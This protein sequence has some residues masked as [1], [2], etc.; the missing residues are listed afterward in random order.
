MFGRG[1]RGMGKQR[2]GTQPGSWPKQQRDCVD[3]GVYKRKTDSMTKQSCA[4]L[5]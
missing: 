3:E 5:T 2:R 1:M 4:E